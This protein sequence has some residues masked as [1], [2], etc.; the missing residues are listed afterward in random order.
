MATTTMSLIGKQTV[1]GNSAS[2]ITF[3]NI[4][5]TYTDLIVKWSTRGTANNGGFSIRF[6]EDTSSSNYY[7]IDLHTQNGT[8]VQSFNQS[9]YAGYN[10]YIFAWRSEE[11]TS[12][13][14]SH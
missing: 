14:Q 9:T 3:S 8:S 2:S 1:G 11:H 13:L 5:Q 6:N 12:E 7:Y 10:T 4:P